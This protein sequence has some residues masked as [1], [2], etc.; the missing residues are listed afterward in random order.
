MDGTKDS[1][2]VKLGNAETPAAVKNS[3]KVKLGN[4][5]TPA[6]LKTKR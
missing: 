3:G 4:A 1:G 6:L 2:K 5:E